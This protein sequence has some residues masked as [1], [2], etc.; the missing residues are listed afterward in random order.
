MSTHALKASGT[1][2]HRQLYVI[3]R[4]DILQGKFRI[5]DRLPTQEA[6]CGQF[7]VSRITVR[8]ALADLQAEGLVRSERGVGAFVTHHLP[9]R[10][11]PASLALIAAARQ[12]PGLSSAKLLE[13]RHEPATVHVAE[14]LQVLPGDEILFMSWLRYSEGR[15]ALYFEAWL[16]PRLGQTV[17]PT[18]LVES[19]LSCLLARGPSAV[20]QVVDEINAEAAHPSVAQALEVEATSPIL[21]RERI[22]YDVEQRPI[23]CVVSRSSGLRSRMLMEARSGSGPSRRTGFLVQDLE[24]RPSAAQDE[25]SA[26]HKA[27]GLVD[28]SSGNP[29]VGSSGDIAVGSSGSTSGDSNGSARGGVAAG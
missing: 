8:R 10:P 2:L 6:L 29:A 11:V 19:T 25:A 21:R 27:G 4:Q 1:L 14:R 16:L 17:T 3:L 22:F 15:I 23:A 28:G 20:G 13:Y 18:S 12:A 26:E 9:A 7:S 24:Q 5:G